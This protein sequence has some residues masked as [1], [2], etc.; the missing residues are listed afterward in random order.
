MDWCSGLRSSALVL[1][2][3][4]ESCSKSMRLERGLLLTLSE[5]VLKLFETR[6]QSSACAH[7]A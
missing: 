2:F 3:I 5:S 6:L 1:D 7:I 4:A